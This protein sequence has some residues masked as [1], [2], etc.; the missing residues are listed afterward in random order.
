MKRD[1]TSKMMIE[2]LARA[3][4]RI[5]APSKRLVD[6]VMH[7]ARA[8]DVSFLKIA[9]EVGVKIGEITDPDGRNVLHHV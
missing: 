7:A 5:A 6:E 1:E 8:G 9:K 4:A 2:L 3:G